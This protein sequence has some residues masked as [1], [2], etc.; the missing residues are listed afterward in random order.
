MTCTYCQ[1]SP[2]NDD[3]EQCVKCGH[4]RN[5]IQHRLDKLER[6]IQKQETR[7]QSL[8]RRVLKLELL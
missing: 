5:I 7:I 3:Y 6:R 1:Y 2:I 8:E 4:I